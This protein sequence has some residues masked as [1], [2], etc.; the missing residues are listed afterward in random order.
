MKANQSFPLQNLIRQATWP[1]SKFNK[2]WATYPALLEDD[3]AGRLHVDHCI[4][5]L[6]LS[7]MCYSDVTPVLAELAPDR[8]TGFQLDFNVHHKCRNYDTIMDYLHKH[9]S[10]VRVGEDGQPE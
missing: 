10:D 9:G 6:R 1:L 7:L 5:T 2:T 4:E 8:P 3:I